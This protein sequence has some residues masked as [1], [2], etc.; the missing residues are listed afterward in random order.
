VLCYAALA[1]LTALPWLAAFACTMRYIADVST[2]LALSGLLGAWWLAGRAR[3]HHPALR[4]LL[5]TAIVALALWTV[6]IGGLLGFT[7]Y[8]EHFQ[9]FNPA[10]MD[11]LQASLS[12]CR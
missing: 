5:V 10:L 1:T 4:I 11:R 3:G 2:G 6:V 7:G 8:I 9:K 12:L